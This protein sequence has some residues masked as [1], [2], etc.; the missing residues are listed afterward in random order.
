MLQAIPVQMQEI[1]ESSVTMID[2]CVELVGVG[3]GLE[4]TVYADIQFLENG[5]SR[6][7]NNI[8]CNINY[9]AYLL[10]YWLFWCL[11]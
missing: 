9:F 5:F 7:S 6:Y 8:F 1:L 2:L 11:R 4:R 10:T 3:A